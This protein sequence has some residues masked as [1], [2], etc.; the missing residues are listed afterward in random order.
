MKSPKAS[1][2]VLSYNQERYIRDAVRAALAQDYEPLEIVISDD[3][4][5]DATFA[6]IEEEV[7][8]YSGPHHLIV[9][10]NPAN[11][12][13]A[14]HLNEAIARTSGEAIIPMSGDDISLPSRVSRI[15]EVFARDRPL[16]V[17]S[18]AYVIDENGDQAIPGHFLAS[19]FQ[20][21]DPKEIATSMSLYLGASGGWHRDLIDRYGPIEYEQCYDDLIFGFRAAL[22][23]RVAFIEDPLLYY[24]QGIGISARKTQAKGRRANAAH[25]VAELD[26]QIATL[27]Q[28]LIDARAFGLTDADPVIEKIVRLQNRL[29]VRAG[30]Y[31]GGV[32]IIRGLI[33][34]PRLTMRLG[35]SE[36]VRF[37]RNR[38]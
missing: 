7:R 36:F 12:G 2:I 15:M 19:F 11:R 13:Y 1:V 14:P 32:S 8:A 26:F 28:R 5:S 37:L 3:A 30:V 6:M 35:F 29:M 34:H 18:H 22:E 23:G 27:A 20:S 10:R 33:A 38:Y 21:T 17:H 4:S 24:R 31:R 25:R 9:N 16:L